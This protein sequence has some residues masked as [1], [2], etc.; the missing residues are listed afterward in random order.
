MRS[1][2]RG[3]DGSGCIEVNC[4]ERGGM[5]RGCVDEDGTLEGKYQEHIMAAVAVG[6]PCWGRAGGSPGGG[7]GRVLVSLW[8]CGP[9]TGVICCQPGPDEDW[10]CGEESALSTTPSL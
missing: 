6:C 9:W 4:V 1:S 8:E 10:Q 3:L 5:G 7:E 2:A